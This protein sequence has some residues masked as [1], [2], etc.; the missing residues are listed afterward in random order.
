MNLKTKRLLI[1]NI[2]IILAIAV[3]ISTIKKHLD[4]S[5]VDNWPHVKGIVIFSGV[6][7]Q[8]H[9]KRHKTS[10]SYTDSYD[11]YYV[12]RIKYSYQVNDQEYQSENFTLEDKGVSGTA[13]FDGTGKQF[14][15]KNTAKSE[16]KKYHRGRV[17]IVYYNPSDP[18][19]A[20]L[21][22]SNASIVPML[23]SFGFLGFAF[24]TLF[25]A[26]EKIKPENFSWRKNT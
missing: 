7:E 17:V 19:I 20:S 3:L 14:F 1:A 25:I 2:L 22:Q 6:E 8:K 10:S 5:N 15:D 16:A 4:R 18:E 23:L 11:L 26:L 21:S 13:I 24:L 12:Q 9:Y